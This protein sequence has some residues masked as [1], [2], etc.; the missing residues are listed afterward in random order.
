MV[1][2]QVEHGRGA[3]QLGAPVVELLLQQLALQALARLRESLQIDIPLRRLFDGPTVAE[4]AAS[5][6]DTPEA[7]ARL[8]QVAELALEVERLS[9]EELQAIV[10][11]S[12]ERPDGPSA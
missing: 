11:R 9:P 6:A 3:L 5:L 12:G 8:D 1:G 2:G 7:A 10:A 4:L